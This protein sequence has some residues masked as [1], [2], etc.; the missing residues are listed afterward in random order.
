MKMILL[1]DLF[2]IPLKYYSKIN[3]FFEFKNS[4]KMSILDNESCTIKNI[5]LLI[6]NISEATASRRMTLLRSVLGKPKPKIIIVKDFKDYY[7]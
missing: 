5:Q 2:S 4:V 3:I 7:L 6:P 1:N